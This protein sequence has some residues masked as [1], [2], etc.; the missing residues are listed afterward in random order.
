[1]SNRDASR[2]KIKWFEQATAPTGTDAAV[3]S[4]QDGIT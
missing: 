4:P 2:I 3:V 1:M